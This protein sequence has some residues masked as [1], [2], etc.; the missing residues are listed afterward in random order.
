MNATQEK[1][2]ELGRD[3]IQQ[4]GYHSFSY[5]QIA[6]ILN[7]KNAAVHHYYPAKEDLG[8]AVIEKDRS[9][10][11]RMVEA[12]V[13]DTATAKTEALLKS[14]EQYFADDNK[15]CMV[16]TLGSAFKDIP[17][18]MQ[19]ASK[20]YIDEIAKWLTNTFKDGVASGEFHFKGTAD[21]MTTHWITSLS[22]S[23]IIGRLRGQ[24]YFDA[25]MNLLRTSIKTG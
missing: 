11:K 5:K 13:N 23:L 9:D 21:E 15:L 6:A 24:A 17:E 18:K 22:G 16:G 19:S 1:I 10:F 14:Y 8:L 4:V 2:V 20:A 12:T 25:T 3:F 7:I